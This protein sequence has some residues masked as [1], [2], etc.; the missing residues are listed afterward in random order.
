MDK[1]DKE[2]ILAE[3][4]SDDSPDFEEAVNEIIDGYAYEILE[5]DG[6]EDC[7]YC[8]LGQLFE[9]VY[10]MGMIDAKISIANSLID[11]ADEDIKTINEVDCDDDLN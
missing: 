8:L 3:E 1:K 11:S 9:Q 2:R 6:N 10:G 4:W 5:H 7:L